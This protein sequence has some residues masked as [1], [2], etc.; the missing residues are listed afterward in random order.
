[1]R[2]GRDLISFM[3]IVLF[4]TKLQRAHQ[5]RYGVRDNHACPSQRRGVGA[6]CVQSKGCRSNKKRASE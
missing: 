4:I 1:M 5:K 2:V 3:E 6:E